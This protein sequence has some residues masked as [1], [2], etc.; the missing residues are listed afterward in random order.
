MRLQIPIRPT[1]IA[2]LLASLDGIPPSRIRMNPFPGTATIRDLD[3]PENKLCELL[4]GTLVEKP[5]GF[6]ESILTGLIAGKICQFI[7][8]T[9][10][11]CVTG[12]DGMYQLF[13]GRARGPDVAFIPWERFPNGVRPTE[14]V[15][16]VVPTFVIEVLSKSNTKK[17]MNRKRMEY[18]EAGVLLV[19][20]IDPKSRSAKAYTDHNQ[21]VAYTS[22]GK[23]SAGEVLPG[24]TLNLKELFAR[25]DKRRK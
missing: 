25:L 10:L 5:I 3:K 17:E 2:D 12:S 20:E 6:S 13:P 9:D 18:F 16:R 7:E 14:S 15:P 8:E 24:F 4:A 11:G 21:F 19:W 1:T 22:T 23:M